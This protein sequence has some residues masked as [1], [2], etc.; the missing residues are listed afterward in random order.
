MQ[1]KP[2]WT[3][4]R[5]LRI[6]TL[7]AVLLRLLM[8]L[9]LGDNLTSEQQVRAFD[10]ITYHR[11]SQ[12]ILAGRGY[13]FD[14]DYYPGFTPAGQPTAQW[15]FLYPLYLAGI[16]AITGP[17]PLAAR[18]IQVIL[19]GVLETWLVFRLGRA[20]FNA[21][22]GLISAGLSAIYAYFIFYDA[23]LMTE[24]FFISSVLA[25]ILLGLIVSGMAKDVQST[26][27]SILFWFL[28]GL[29]MGIAALFRQTILLW[30]PFQ[31]L[32][33]A[34]AGRKSRIPWRQILVGSAIV[35]AL[36][37]VMILPWT[38]RNFIFYQA[39]LP[40]N[41]NAGYA[42]Y[43][44]NHPDHG[45]RFDQDYAAPLPVDLLNKGLN[46]AEWNTILSQRGLNFA[47]QNPER[48]L[49]LTM[50]K[51]A[52]HFNFWFSR[53]SSLFSNLMRVFSYG[54]YLPFFIIG[55]AISIKD[56]RRCSLI[57]LFVIVFSLLHILTWS[58]I[59]Y[60][61]PV[62]ALLMPFAGLSILKIMDWIKTW[63]ANIK[64]S[65]P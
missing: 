40:L 46:E 19:V 28:L 47:L 37:I 35:I 33:I 57:Y 27:N 13:S 59:R 55:L 26:A 9:Y 53:E 1:V 42:I 32:W 8:A 44:A 21:K 34:W 50:S 23:T 17:H 20:L 64:P 36:V 65:Y 41:S 48:Y 54:L 7:V 45:I 61:L 58:G 25:M 31:L 10:Q 49:K 6:I 38:I 43:S 30:L 39:F 51:V 56:W 62:D 5:I 4:T 18:L 12:S 60:R 29:T 3:E 22:I 2:F 14:F 16:Y 52:V 15:S 24:P 63:S 11:L